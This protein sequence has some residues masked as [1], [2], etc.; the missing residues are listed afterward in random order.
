MD[1]YYDSIDMREPIMGSVAGGVFTLADTTLYPGLTM[2]DD[3]RVKTNFNGSTPKGIRFAANVVTSIRIY[4]IDESIWDIDER[5]YD[6]GATGI[7]SAS[8]LLINRDDPAN[9]PEVEVWAS[10][11]RITGY[12]KIFDGAI[13]SGDSWSINSLTP[14]S[15]KY[16]VVQ[17]KGTYNIN[18]GEIV[19]A[20]RITDLYHYDLGYSEQLKPF[21][22]MKTSIT[23]NECSNKIDDPQNIKSMIWGSMGSTYS[24]KIE[25]LKQGISG[26][27]KAFLCIDNDVRKY[28][29]LENDILLTEIS[30]NQQATNLD[31]RSFL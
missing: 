15:A 9:N 11:D 2:D 21:L 19:L 24:D 13:E 1:F 4:D 12:T 30:N 7:G 18:I 16:F 10:S 22:K 3:I 6:L 31:I 27:H 14:T 28:G 20:Q 8:Y 29:K 5:I 23:G 26:K 17:F 25:S